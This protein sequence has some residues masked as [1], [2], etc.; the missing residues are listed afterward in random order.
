ML[1]YVAQWAGDRGFVHHSAVQ[2]RFPAFE[3]D[4]T[5]LDAEVAGKR[6]D[7]T[8]GAKIVTLEVV[9]TTQDGAVMAKGPV[10]VE[11]P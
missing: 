9:M 10:E 8:L 5:F 6:E 7:A 4:V 11:L 3:G 1:D 2:Y